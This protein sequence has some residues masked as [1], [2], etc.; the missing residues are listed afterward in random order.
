MSFADTV[1]FHEA[2][3]EAYDRVGYRTIVV[4]RGPIELRAAFVLD[5]VHRRR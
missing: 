1:P 2:I 3:V 4:P 5:V